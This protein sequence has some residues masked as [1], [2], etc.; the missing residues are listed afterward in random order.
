MA[1]LSATQGAQISTSSPE[2]GHGVFTYYFLKALNEGKTNVA[3][4]YESIQ[5]QIEDEAKQLNVQQ[6]PTISPD[7]KKLKG[8]FVLR[9]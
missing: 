8:R 9:K 1:I 6:S 5:P 2:R 4:I 3:D 7:S